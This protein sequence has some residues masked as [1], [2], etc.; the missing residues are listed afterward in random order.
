VCG[1]DSASSALGPAE[2]ICEHDIESPRLFINGWGF[3]NNLSDY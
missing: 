2:S 1:L 3:L